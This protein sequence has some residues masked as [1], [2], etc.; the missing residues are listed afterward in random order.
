MKRRINEILSQANHYTNDFV[1]LNREEITEFMTDFKSGE[2]YPSLIT[3]YNFKKGRREEG[4]PFEGRSIIDLMGSNRRRSFAKISALLE[5]QKIERSVENYGK[6]VLYIMKEIV[7]I[8]YQN[9]VTRDISYFYEPAYFLAHRFNEMLN[10]VVKN[11]LGIKSIEEYY[12]NQF[13]ENIGKLLREMDEFYRKIFYIFDETAEKIV[14]IPDWFNEENEPFYYDSVDVFVVL[15]LIK[16]LIVID[17]KNHQ[18]YKNLLEIFLTN[19]LHTQRYGKNFNSYFKSKIRHIFAT[20]E[21]FHS[22]N[23]EIK[24]VYQPKL[25]WYKEITT[26]SKL[27]EKRSFEAKIKAKEIK[28][29]ILEK[30]GKKVYVTGKIEGITKEDIRTKIEQKGYVWSSSIT[31]NLDLLIEAEKPGPSKIEKAKNL[32]I[33]IISWDKFAELLEKSKIEKDDDSEIKKG[34]RKKS[35]P[36]I[37]ELIQKMK[38]NNGK[39]RLEA[40]QK[41]GKF[42]DKIVFDIFFS[43]LEDSN[44]QNRKYAFDFLDEK[45]QEELMNQMYVLSANENESIVKFV[46]GEM[47]KSLHRKS[48][49]ILI[50]VFE[51]QSNVKI[52]LETLKAL[53]RKNYEKISDILEKI[54]RESDEANLVSYAFS[55][56]KKLHYPEMIKLAFVVLEKS[57]FSLKRESFDYLVRNKKEKKAVEVLIKQYYSKMGREKN[58]I[59]KI[60]R[61]IEFDEKEAIIKDAINS[62]S[63]TL[64]ILGISELA[65]TNQDTA[66]EYLFEE[67]NTPFVS[68]R[69]EVYKELLSLFGEKCFPIIEKALDDIDSTVKFRVTNEVLNRFSRE[70]LE[71]LSKR[72]LEEKN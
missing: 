38:N 22:I 2:K 62:E 12:K 11:I 14:C 59:F 63:S 48:N 35:S 7:E 54:I 21:I 58:H 64:R 52:L 53:V 24:D 27:E 16:W 10:F 70:K 71:V 33:P 18:K 8:S 44:Q 46:V 15:T 51:T 50:H 56:L 61:K 67:T 32:G 20:K 68:E 60:L 25:F 29:G 45:K 72:F 66:F 55:S 28:T 47:K 4:Q 36:E 37:Q 49:S 30:E 43:A 17:D 23:P 41:L 19:F 65:K 31:K 6:F 13:D 39:I 34:E 42:D 3:G 5:E 9:M 40:L 26:K 69:I 1:S 57:N